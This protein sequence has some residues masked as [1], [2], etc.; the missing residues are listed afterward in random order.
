MLLGSVVLLVAKVAFYFIMFY[1]IYFYLP[2]EEKQGRASKGKK[3]QGE[4]SK[5]KEGLAFRSGLTALVDFSF[6]FG[7]RT[8]RQ[9]DEGNP[10]TSHRVKLSPCG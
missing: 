5:G 2:L 10:R 8:S 1:F 4:G 7:P 9:A 6:S 3:G